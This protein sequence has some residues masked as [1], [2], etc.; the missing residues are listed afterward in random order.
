[1]TQQ[2]DI[3]AIVKPF[4]GDVHTA[5]DGFA[6]RAASLEA[7]IGELQAEQA[8]LRRQLALSGA[9]GAVYEPERKGGWSAESRAL[10]RNYLEGKSVSQMSGATPEAG[11]F[12]V[13]QDIAAD[14]ERLVQL[15]SPVR[16]VADVRRATTPRTRLLVSLNDAT[17][18]WVGETASRPTTQS[19]ELRAVEPPIGTLY[20]NADVTEELVE[21]FV[22]DFDIFLAETV[23]DQFASQEGAA[24]I[25]GDG[26]NKPK[27]FT[28]YTAV[29]SGDAT[30][31]FGE[32]QYI[33]TGSASSLGTALPD[34]LIGMVFATKAAYRQAEGCAFM[35][36]TA[37]IQA[38]SELKIG[39]GDARPLYLP[40]LRE[41]TPGLLL[42]FPLVEAEHMPAVASGAFPIAFGNWQRGYT[43]LDRTETT[44]LRDP[45]SKKGA[46]QFY[47]RKRVGG[48]VR[49]SEAIKLLKVATS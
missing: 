19:P 24:F 38:L 5:L 1:M 16:S 45:Y 49:N 36:N 21:D 20:A 10:L 25:S 4:V 15:Q 3:E 46:V 37:T 48:A 29:A 26:V 47:V 33:P 34:K 41:G 22:N 30:R 27:G 40:S 35:A 39:T 44:I 11:G 6:G 42:G 14:I 32:L 18:G 17:S 7:V 9:A 8:N 2:F 12:A 43:I 28:D 31:A 13:P 23:V